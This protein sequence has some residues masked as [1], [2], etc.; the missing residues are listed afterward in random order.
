MP[1][2]QSRHLDGMAIYGIRPNEEEMRARATRDK[3]DFSSLVPAIWKTPRLSGPGHYWT[4]VWAEPL[5][6]GSAII[7]R[8]R[9]DGRIEGAKVSPGEWE[10]V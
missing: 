5:E 10:R 2:T 9:R 4:N 7:Y 8:Y 6:D 1:G 3:V